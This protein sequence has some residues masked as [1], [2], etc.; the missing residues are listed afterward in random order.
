MRPIGVLHS[1]FT[2]PAGTPIQGVY[3]PESVGTAEVFA[4]FA[5]GLADIEGFSH[6]YLIYLFDRSPGY[7]LT[8]M[9]SRDSTPRGVF[10]T[11]APRRPNPLGLSIV[12][13]VAREGNLLRLAEVD[14]LDGTPLL[15]IKPYVP[16]FDCRA[17]CRSG[18]LEGGEDRTVADGRFA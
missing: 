16:A 17:D 4:E 3:A 7:A 12:R 2:E 11:R 13:L 9:P 5:E 10:A 14:F 8:V 1:P 6:L 15:D 18:W